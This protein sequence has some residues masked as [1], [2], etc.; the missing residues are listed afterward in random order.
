M[1]TLADW[2]SPC[3]CSL[4]RSPRPGLPEL[5]GGGGEPGRRRLRL[6][7]GYS[8]SILVMIG[9]PFTMLGAGDVLSSPAPGR[10]GALPEL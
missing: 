5:Q 6:A 8:W 9:M 4:R 1:R 10:R 3:S 2:P 7:D